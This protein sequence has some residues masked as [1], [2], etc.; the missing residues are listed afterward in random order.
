VKDGVVFGGVD[1]QRLKEGGA[2][3]GL[4]NG[5]MLQLTLGGKRKGEAACVV[6]RRSGI[7]LGKRG[8]VTMAFGHRVQGKWMARP[9]PWWLHALQVDEGAWQAGLGV[10]RER[11][12]QVDP[13][14]NNFP[15]FHLKLW[16]SYWLR[17]T[18]Y[19][20]VKNLE[21]HL[22]G[23]MDNLEQFS[24]LEVCL[25]LN[26]VWIR[27]KIPFQFWISKNWILR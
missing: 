27:D 26:G 24:L 6:A 18:S 11:G 4:N 5:D 23:R 14:E 10:K 25:K 19:K 15:D 2:A 21:K 12:R 9:V 16:L 7:R 20:C 13:T 1:G 22:R 3:P 17:I 8:M